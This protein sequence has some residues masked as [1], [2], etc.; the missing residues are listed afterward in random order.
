MVGVL[1]WTHFHYPLVLKTG[2]TGFLRSWAIAFIAVI[3]TGLLE[4]KRL[5]LRV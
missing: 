2:V 5:R 4:R 3:I 1:K